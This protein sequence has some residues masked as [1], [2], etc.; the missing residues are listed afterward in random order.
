MYIY[1][2]MGFATLP[3]L[4]MGLGINVA[5]QFLLTNQ[6][7]QLRKLALKNDLMAT[8]QQLVNEMDTLAYFKNS[9]MEEVVK[10]SAEN[11]ELKSC[12]EEAGSCKGQGVKVEDLS[13]ELPDGQ[14]LSKNGI[15]CVSSRGSNCDCP[16]GEMSYHCPFKKTVEVS[17]L[18]P[19]NKK[20][21]EKAEGL[22]FSFKV[23]IYGDIQQE[24]RLEGIKKELYISDIFA[25]GSGLS[26][27]C[28]AGKIVTRFNTDGSVECR[29]PYK[30]I[31]LLQFHVISLGIGNFWPLKTLFKR[32]IKKA[33]QM[34]I[35][36]IKAKIIAKIQEKN[37]GE[38]P[39]SA[40]H[41]NE[42]RMGKTIK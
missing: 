6:V 15:Q 2:K 31:D 18:C 12:I 40:R 42:Q 27:I 17:P 25:Q 1:E 3:V 33:T 4:L 29:S 7:L 21:C 19:G 24:Y 20:E 8:K 11:P 36:K 22:L 9:I 34:I 35:D 13:I 16:N 5:I 41:K 38:S 23:E 39:Q 37:N 10:N 28:P 14:I 32:L 26:T 30:D